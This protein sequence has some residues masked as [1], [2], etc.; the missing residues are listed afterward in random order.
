M[1][2]DERQLGAMLTF[3][4]SR[5]FPIVNSAKNVGHESYS[6]RNV[7]RESFQSRTHPQKTLE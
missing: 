5:I 3:E 7:G 1:Y 2:N 4:A 6:T